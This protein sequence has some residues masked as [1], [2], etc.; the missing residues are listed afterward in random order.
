MEIA[1]LAERYGAYLIVDEAH[2]T[3]CYGTTGAGCIDAAG[4]RP[5][6]LASVHTGGKALACRAPTSSV[7][8]LLK[9]YLTNRC[10]HL[11]FTTALPPAIGS[12]WIEGIE[13][14]QGDHESR[15][16]LHKNTRLFR[17]ELTNRG[18]RPAG[19]EYV[20]PVIIGEDPAAVRAATELQAKGFDIRAI[21]PPTVA[22][23]TSRLRI[24][25]HANH[26]P[27]TLIDLADCV[28]SVCHV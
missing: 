23:G 16:R 22:Q 15:R 27:Q 6:V 8:K 12:W 25:V 5:R 10:R 9:E 24:S 7:R 26:E 4:V 19:T 17:S 11:I 3:G 21:R 2:S 28:A 18:V 13:R 14:V 20:V 1:T